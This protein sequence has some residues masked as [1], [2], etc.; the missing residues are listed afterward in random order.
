[1]SE[2]RVVVLV[3]LDVLRKPSTNTFA[4]RIN[5]LGLTAYGKTHDEAV[6]KVKRMFAASVQAHR[7]S[8][9]LTT[10]LDRSELEWHWESEYAGPVP[11]EDARIS[12][13]HTSETAASAISQN[14]WINTSE[15]LPVAA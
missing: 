2:E 12:E 6:Q 14:N 4:A 8:H 11:V 7:K 5:Q 15:P 9:S 13:G 3:K 1:M 10:W